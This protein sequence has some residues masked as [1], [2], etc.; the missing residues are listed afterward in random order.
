MSIVTTY[1]TLGANLTDICNTVNQSYY[2]DVTTGY[3]R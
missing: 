3:K 2:G 1:K